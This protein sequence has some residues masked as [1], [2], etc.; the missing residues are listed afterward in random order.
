M[1][2]PRNAAEWAAVAD[3]AEALNAASDPDLVRQLAFQPPCVPFSPEG[4][5]TQGVPAAST[6]APMASTRR[7]SGAASSRFRQADELPS[8]LRSRGGPEG[9]RLCRHLQK[10]PHFRR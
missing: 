6:I 2:F 4:T 8:L 1:S 7:G 5:P 10:G 3:W 9:L